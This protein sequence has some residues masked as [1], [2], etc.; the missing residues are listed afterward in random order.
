[1]LRNESWAVEADLEILF[2]TTIDLNAVHFAFCIL[3][4]V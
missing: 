1:M 3:A 4:A 2:K